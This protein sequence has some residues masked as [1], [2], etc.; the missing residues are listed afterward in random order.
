M[1]AQPPVRADDDALQHE[2]DRVSLT[3]ALFDTE[4]ATAR[5][6]DLTERLVGARQQI[7]GLRGELESLKTEYAQYRA[8]Q[9][10]IQGSRAFRLAERLWALRNALGI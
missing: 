7:S 4:V 1:N 10:R 6:I 9:D 8:E 3:Q 2:L 5:V